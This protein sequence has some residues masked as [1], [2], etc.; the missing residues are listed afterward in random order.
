MKKLIMGIMGLS[1]LAGV[2]CG[3][4]GGDS[5]AQVRVMNAAPE[6]QTLDFFLDGDLF[7][8]DL[9]YGLASDYTITHSGDADFRMTPG[10]SNTTLA[11]ET[12]DFAEDADY[13]VLLTGIGETLDGV[14]YRDDNTLPEPGNSKLRII[15]AAPSADNIDVYVTAIG[16]DISVITPSI[17]DLEFKDAADYIQN[18]EGEYQV[19][20]TAAGTKSPVLI[21]DTVPLAAGQVKTAVALDA[22]G[23]GEPFSL[24][25]LTDIE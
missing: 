20:V 18:P 15:H 24:Q 11:T 7:L 23:G 13:T 21:D 4:D 10:D 8:G 5:V 22:T 3:N 25:T 17:S 14:T 19:R 2:G 12:S 16:A 9:N 1:L 6:Y